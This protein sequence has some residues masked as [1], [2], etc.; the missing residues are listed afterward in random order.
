MIDSDNKLGTLVMVVESSIYVH[1]RF[2]VFLLV[3]QPCYGDVLQ[4]LSEIWA[5][6]TEQVHHTIIC[7]RD[8]KS[9]DLTLNYT[10]DFIF[11]QSNARSQFVGRHGQRH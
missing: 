7:S 1:T 11:R 9:F 3:Q 10:H 4:V 5:I 6:S 2:E 8:G